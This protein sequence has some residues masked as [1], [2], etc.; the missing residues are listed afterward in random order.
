MAR[1]QCDTPFVFCSSVVQFYFLADLVFI[2][3]Y[4]PGPEVKSEPRIGDGTRTNHET[5]FI[6]K[7]FLKKI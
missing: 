4:D 2:L 5:R 3:F 6:F 1:S 7:T